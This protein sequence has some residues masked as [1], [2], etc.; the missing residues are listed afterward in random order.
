MRR[1]EEK[2]REGD[3][4]VSKLIHH[5]FKRPPLVFQIRPRPD[6]TRQ[7]PHDRGPMVLHPR[8][9]DE[10][11]LVGHAVDDERLKGGEG[12]FSGAAAWEDVG[13]GGLEVHVED[14]GWSAM[15]EKL[16][17]E[18]KRE[19]QGG[20]RTVEDSEGARSSESSGA[21]RS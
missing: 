2:G 5:P 21:C 6:V 20:T 8:K 12:V 9:R 3:E 11:F 19:D 18:G 13:G 4:P 14:F 7:L 16:S 1:K 15:E 10:V 17:C